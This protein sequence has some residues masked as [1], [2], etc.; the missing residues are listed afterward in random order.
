MKKIKLFTICMLGLAT[1]ALTSCGDVDDEIT[2][3]LL[4]RNLSPINLEA[5]NVGET[6]ADIQWTL[7]ENATSYNLEIFADDSLT[8]A[9][10]PI[11]TITGIAPTDIPVSVS[12]LLFDTQYSVRVQAVTEGNDSRT[13]TWQG[14]Y[15]RTGT[16]QF[17]KNP[18]PAQIADRSVTLTWEVEEGYDV[19][20]IVVGGITHQ[21]TAEEKAA[22]QATIEGLTP[23][24]TYTAYLY[25]NGKQCGN[26]TFT[27]IAD[28]AG[29]VLVHE[30]DDFKA[31]LE[32]EALADGTVFALY[33]GTYELNVN[34]EGM[35]GAVKISKSI[36]IKGIY[37]TDQPQIKGRFELYDGAGLAISQCFIDGRSNATTDQLFNFK[38]DG[39]DYGKLELENCI[40]TGQT[41][42]KGILYLNV[43]STVEAININ[44]CIVYGIECSGGDFIDSRK[45]LPREVNL[46]KSTF[47][48]IATARDFIRIDDASGS[49]EGQDGPKV[50]VDN[51]TL[52]NVGAGA[53]NYR[54]LYVRFVGNKLTFTNNIVVGTNYKRG[55]TNQSKSDQEPTLQNNYYFNCEN[56]TSA[57]ASADATISWF[58]T[59]GTVADPKFKNPEGGD[60][61]LNA[62][63]AA[64]KGK[65]GDP[66]WWA[67]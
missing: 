11:K 31:M 64:N 58:D 14:A 28:L 21:V 12:G 33:G 8:F 51:C 20:T 25:Y 48:T 56:L 5:K 36:T 38:T 27:T 53:A 15:F 16:K 42:C 3:L 1:F 59:E 46:T 6:T 19:T 45:G 67:K 62:D 10:S 52:Y 47:F 65:A 17:L 29:A 50:K 32:D 43:T 63:A 30:E 44:N 40:I 49:F 22:G 7:S 55:F 34:D 2:S 4:K 66:R 37:P 9:G 26:R 24:T 57:G 35:T 60:F 39:V 61:T 13:S 23:E 54:L 41:D 18:K